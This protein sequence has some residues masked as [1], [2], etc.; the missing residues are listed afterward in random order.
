MP[1]TKDKEK[2]RGY[3][4]KWRE[5]HPNYPKEWRRKH[6]NY[7]PNYFSK[8]FQNLKLKVLTHYGYGKPQCIHCG[9]SDIRALSLDHTE[10]NGTQHRKAIKRGGG[11]SFYKWLYDN[12]LPEGY[13]TLCMNCQF[14][15]RFENH[16]TRQ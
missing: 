1:Y 6:P 12:D 13:Q 7:F 9:F 3:N 10:G 5:S 4:R 14:I 16:E 11:L 2:Q 8:Y 15:K